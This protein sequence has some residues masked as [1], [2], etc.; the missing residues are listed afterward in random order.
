MSSL[1]KNINTVKCSTEGCD[2]PV[3][4]KGSCRKHHVSAYMLKTCAT[5][6]CNKL[7]GRQG[8]KGH[9]SVHYASP[10]ALKSCA[11][12]GCNELVGTNGQKGYC[13]THYV[14]HAMLAICNVEGCDKKAWKKSACSK[15]Y[16]SPAMLGTC[17]IRGCSNKVYANHACKVHYQRT[18]RK[19][20]PEPPE[21]DQQ[22]THGYIIHDKTGTPVYVGITCNFE[23]RMDWHKTRQPWGTYVNIPEQPS[24]TFDNREQASEWERQTIAKLTQTTSLFNDTYNPNWSLEYEQDLLERTIDVHLQ[25]TLLQ[26]MVE[27]HA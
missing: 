24:V 10:A 12:Q 11:I 2:K 25:H 4:A 21:L 27:S 16:V 7:V 3:H 13:Y 6:G 23:P 18:Y 19:G 5:E 14:S 26:N 9:C 20:T 1:D 15:H 8:G 17:N 22:T